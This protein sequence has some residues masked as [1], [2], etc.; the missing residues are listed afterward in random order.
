MDCGS[1]AMGCEE[2]ELVQPQACNTMCCGRVGGG[3]AVR[4][5]EG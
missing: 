3:G 5:T 4:D 1:Y 2:L